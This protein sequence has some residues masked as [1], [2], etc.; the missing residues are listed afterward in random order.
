MNEECQ[1][2]MSWKDN[3]V[4]GLIGFMGVGGI[5]GLA[6]LDISSSEQKFGGPVQTLKA[7][8]PTATPGTFILAEFEVA[9]AQPLAL[10]EQKYIA[11]TFYRAAVHLFSAQDF[12]YNMPS[13]QTQMSSLLLRMG[14]GVGADVRARPIGLIPNC[15]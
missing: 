7:C 3:V 9:K 4:L 15:A 11:D 12:Y 2:P 6:A 14:S 10:R 13:A 5:C 1:Q 8:A